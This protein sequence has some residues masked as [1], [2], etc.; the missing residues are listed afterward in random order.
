MSASQLPLSLSPAT[1]GSGPSS[2]G[3]R[4]SS[5]N[6]G[7]TGPAVCFQAS[8]RSV[9][10]FGS[11]QRRHRGSGGAQPHQGGGEFRVSDRAFHGAAKL[12]PAAVLCHEAS[13]AGFAA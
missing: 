3:S 11:V 12:S 8:R 1:A 13:E 10:L 6:R 2:P 4:V 5:L 9:S 7:A